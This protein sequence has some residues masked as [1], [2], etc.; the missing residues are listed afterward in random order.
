METFLRQLPHGRAIDLNNE[1]TSFMDQ[2][3][4]N[5][6][7]M[8]ASIKNPR[9]SLRFKERARLSRLQDHRKNIKDTHQFRKP[10]RPGTTKNG[11]P[12]SKHTDLRNCSKSTPW[13]PIENPRS[14]PNPMFGKKTFSQGQPHITFNHFISTIY[15]LELSSKITTH[16]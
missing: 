5:V 13:E 6:L 7:K 16:K 4:D 3:W 11:W 12:R 1:D 9:K 10:G 15:P 8:R 2:V 14:T